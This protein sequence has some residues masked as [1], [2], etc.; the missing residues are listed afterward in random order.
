MKIANKTVRERGEG[1]EFGVLSSIGVAYFAWRES[2]LVRIA[3]VAG[4]RVPAAVLG[5]GVSSIAEEISRQLVMDIERGGVGR[6]N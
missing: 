4:G 6:R 3:E 5:H 2:E 1:E